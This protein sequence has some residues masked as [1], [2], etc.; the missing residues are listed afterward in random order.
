MG[1]P[2]VQTPEM[3]ARFVEAIEAGASLRL[4]SGAAGVAWATAQRWHSTDED[5]RAAVDAAR[6]RRATRWLRIIETIANGEDEQAALRA[7]TWLLEHCETEDFGK[8]VKTS[9]QEEIR[10]FIDG[11]RGK[12][13]SSAWREVMLAAS[14]AAGAGVVRERPGA[15]PEQH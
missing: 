1:R 6:G 8:S 7:A 11:L 2:T 3:V 13:G 5:F 10:S 4:A 14:D 15:G 9:V 12:L